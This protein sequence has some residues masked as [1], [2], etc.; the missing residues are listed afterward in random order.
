MNP[1]LTLTLTLL[2][3]IS[4]YWH[5]CMKMCAEA[6]LTHHH[7]SQ[8]GYEAMRLYY[9]NLG[10]GLLYPPPVGPGAGLEL[11]LPYPTPVG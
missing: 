7:W 6:N 9:R 2:G 8:V 5:L 1:T 4:P 11:G 3:D 10:L